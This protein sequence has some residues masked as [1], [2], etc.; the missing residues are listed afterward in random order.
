MLN[1]CHSGECGGHLFGMDTTQKILHV[2]YLWP[3]IFKYCHEVVNKFPPSQ[4]FYP[5]KRTHPAPLHPIIA[6]GPFFKW[7]I[8]FMHCKPTSAG[9]H[10]YIIVAMDY[11]TKWAEAMPTYV[12]DG[13][14]TTLFLFNHVRVARFGVPWSIVMDRRSHFW[15]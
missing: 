12:D 2:G 5:K 9:G 1:D 8:Y 7:G 14:S 6:V 11:F 10:G 15:N 3:S 13:K 4:Q